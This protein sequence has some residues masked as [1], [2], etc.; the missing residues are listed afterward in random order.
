MYMSD[1][2]L[3]NRKPDPK[4]RTL[5][6]YGISCERWTTLTETYCRSMAD[7]MQQHHTSKTVNLSWS[8]PEDGWIQ[9]R[10]KISKAKSYSTQPDKEQNHSS[11]RVEEPI[12][13]IQ[14]PQGGQPQYGPL[15]ETGTRFTDW[16]VKR[17]VSSRYYRKTGVSRHHG[18]P[19]Y[20]PMKLLEHHESKV[21]WVQIY[22]PI[23]SR[24]GTVRI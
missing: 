23:M 13:I 14:G 9:D 3:H 8:Q 11:L 17:V 22:A 4:L 10:R 12:K 20:C 7:Q 15:K 18:G 5:W 2:Y 21:R 1:I 6:N 16:T 24:E 19:I